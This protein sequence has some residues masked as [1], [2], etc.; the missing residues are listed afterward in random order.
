MPY[1]AAICCWVRRFISRMRWI[2]LCTGS[3]MSKVVDF[4]GG[5]DGKI[6][7]HAEPAF[8]IRSASTTNN[9]NSDPPAVR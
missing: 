1:F 6:L 2:F 4:W 8:Q 7:A 9:S 3:I 5:N